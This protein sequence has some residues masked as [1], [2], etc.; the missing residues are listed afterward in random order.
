MVSVCIATYNGERYLREQL[1]SILSQIGEND[2]V[3]ISDDGS[4]DGTLEVL[5]SY[6][7]DKRIKLFN[8]TKK[9][10]VH[11]FENALNNAKGDYIFLCDQDDVWLPG[12]VEK[13][14]NLLQENI[15]VNHNSTLV[16][17]DG[18]SL[19]TNFFSHHKSKKGYFNNLIRNSYCGCCMAF[20]R[21]LLKYILPFPQRIASHDIWIGLVAE[22]RG[23]TAFCDEPLILY[24]RH[25]LNVSSTSEKTR[26]SLY[27]Q[28]EYRAYMFLHSL[29]R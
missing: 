10:F 7:T 8:N 5:N 17:S 21:E 15:I 11:N 22:K 26:L 12:K 13:C 29:L 20:R 14:V 4:T 1:S 23:K 27:T 25:G 16:N 2:E 6:S 3:I 24:R 19:G 18:E 28:I 9:G